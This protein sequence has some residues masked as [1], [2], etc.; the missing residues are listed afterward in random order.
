MVGLQWENLGL[1][2][3]WLIYGEFIVDSCMVLKNIWSM[4]VR[5]MGDN[6]GFAGWGDLQQLVGW[7]ISWKIAEMDDDWDSPMTQ[8]DV[9][10]ISW[11]S[12]DQL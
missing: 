5:N 7:F 1:I 3:G 6:M 2:Y 10:H 8:E 12:N 9:V 4:I 11:D